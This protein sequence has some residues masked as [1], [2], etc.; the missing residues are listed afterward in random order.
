LPVFDQKGLVGYISLAL[1]FGY[2]EKRYFQAEKV[3]KGFHN[4]ES[5]MLVS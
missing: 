1:A 4:Q 5:L 2:E 3:F